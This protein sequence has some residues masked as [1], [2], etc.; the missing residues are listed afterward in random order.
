MGPGKGVWGVS[1]CLGYKHGVLC[2]AVSPCSGYAWDKDLKLWKVR[3]S[4]LDLVVAKLTEAGFMVLRPGEDTP[5]KTQG[6]SSGSAAAA[7]GGGG[8]PA[9]NGE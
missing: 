2:C 9:D 3:R 1:V 8:H 6:A 4:G 7:A 5:A